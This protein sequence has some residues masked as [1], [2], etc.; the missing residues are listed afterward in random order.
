MSQVQESP[1]RTPAALAEGRILVPLD[2]SLRA[3]RALAYATLLPAREVVLFHVAPD[4]L[5]VL[6]GGVPADLPAERAEIED[7]LEEL[8]APLRNDRRDVSVEVAFGDAAE[9][10]IAAAA[11]ASLI[12][13]TTEGRGAA[14]RLLFGSVADRVSRHSATPVLMI[15]S[16]DGE[17]APVPAPARIVVPLDGSER[18][19][20]ALPIATSLASSLGLPLH[21]L[22]AV[23][24]D[25][26]RAQVREQRAVGGTSPDA[27]W[28]DAR[29][30]A[31]ESANA[32]LARVAEGVV[33][34]TGVLDGDPAFALI[35]NTGADDLVV[36][37]SHGR[38][39]LRRWLLG[40]VA[41]KLV[42]EGNGPVLLVP[43]RE[44]DGA[45]A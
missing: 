40:S 13:M 43:T 18:A 35:W 1:T 3:R 4:E 34:Q 6:P 20:R 39:G 29:D 17:D 36:M 2:G 12:V 37:T 44:E 15:R 22:R 38:H 19:E 23:G 31:V 28:D 25:E 26:I 27:T 33:A 8:A 11:E 30:A 32:Y 14:G 9:A 10:I 24:Y 42:R 7:E 5:R 41:E 16:G 45:A 21:L